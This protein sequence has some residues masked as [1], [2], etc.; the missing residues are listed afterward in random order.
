MESNK[1]VSRYISKSQ[2]IVL[3]ANQILIT[4]SSGFIGRNLARK[5]SSSGVRYEA[6]DITGKPDIVA[7]IRN[8]D[9][10]KLDLSKYKCVVHLAA[11]ISV[12]ESFEKPDLYKDVNV[13]S[14]ERLFRACSDA[15]VEKVIFASSAAVYGASEQTLK[16]VGEEDYGG[17]SPYAETKLEGER[18]AQEISSQNTK[19]LCLRFFNVYGRG[20]SANSQYASVIPQFISS[21][22]SGSPVSIH[23]D[24]QQTRD[25]I[26]VEDVSRVILQARGIEIPNFLSVNVGTGIGHSIIKLHDIISKII[27][28]EGIVTPKP[29]FTSS[30]EGDI[31]HSIADIYDLK[32]IIDP[33]SFISLEDGLLELVKRTIDESNY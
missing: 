3:G 33:A 22:L 14:T 20:Q 10:S 12:E 31:R 26:N 29:K 30:R 15:G 28:D 19:F 32:K 6:L 23:G 8:F 5:A 18:I 2:I 25:F 4:G 1:G 21:L 13:S 16:K 9:W 17:S 27:V 24:G 7:D 11:K